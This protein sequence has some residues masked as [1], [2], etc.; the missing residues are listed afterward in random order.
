[1]ARGGRSWEKKQAA[2]AK[3]LAVGDPV[4]WFNRKDYRGWV[5]KVIEPM[6]RVDMPKYRLRGKRGELSYLVQLRPDGGRMGR[7]LWP[8]CNYLEEDKG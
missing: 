7:V 5:V 3:R 1:M 2:I 8:R 6:Q 4:R